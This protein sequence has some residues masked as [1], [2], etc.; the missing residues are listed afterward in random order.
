[1]VLYV[2]TVSY[3]AFCSLI[4]GWLLAIKGST[5]EALVEMGGTYGTLLTGVPVLIAVLVARQQL[6]F[7]RRQHIANIKRSFQPEL[8]ALDEVHLFAE[9]AVNSDLE[10]AKRR[11]EAD[12]IDGMIIDRPAGSELKKYREILPFDIADIVVR[13]SQEIGELFEESKREVP[14]KNI[15]ALRIIEIRTKAGTL[16]AYIQHRRNHLS[17]YW[18]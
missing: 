7:S 1:M 2:V 8:D 18:S 9:I 10:T 6:A 5:V 12:G 14:D 17:Q 13:I 15:L 11:A 4:L 16:S 3:V